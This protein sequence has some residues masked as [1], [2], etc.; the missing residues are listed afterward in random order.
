MCKID[1]T[2]T[3]FGVDGEEGREPRVTLTLKRGDGWTELKMGNFFNDIGQDGYN[4]AG[5]MEIRHLGWKRSLIVQ[6]IE[7]RQN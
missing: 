1:I 4:E 5:L 2:L 3:Y 7:F 6:G